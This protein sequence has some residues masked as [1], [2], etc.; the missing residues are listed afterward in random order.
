MFNMQ[1]K[2]FTLLERLNAIARFLPVFESPGFSFGEMSPHDAG[3]R[4]LPDALFLHE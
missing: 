3:R 2:Q 1:R 4:R